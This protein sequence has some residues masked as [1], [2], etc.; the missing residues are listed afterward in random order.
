MLTMDDDT[1]RFSTNDL[2]V[3][4]YKLKDSLAFLR[5]QPLFSWTKAADDQASR[6][7]I[8]AKGTSLYDMFLIALK[9]LTV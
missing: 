4:E 1:I 8:N 6:A 5:Q 3:V 9:K 7:I 2:R